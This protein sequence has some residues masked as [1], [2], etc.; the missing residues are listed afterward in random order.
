MYWS[1]RRPAED[2]MR[3]VP[4]RR[5]VA[6]HRT[7]CAV[8]GQGGYPNRFRQNR[9]LSCEDCVLRRLRRRT[10]RPRCIRLI[11]ARTNCCSL[12]R[13]LTKQRKATRNQPERAIVARTFSHA[14][15]PPL[16][17]RNRV[18]ALVM[19]F[20]I[21][22]SEPSRSTPCNEPSKAAEIISPRHTSVEGF[23]S[24]VTGHSWYSVSAT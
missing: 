1:G 4:I 23:P 7:L 20:I 16:S 10:S 12:R 14:H 6:G 11:K 17:R 22:D 3:S 24:T 13:E 9:C 21:T 2:Q 8:L 5:P 15:R 19:F 18:T